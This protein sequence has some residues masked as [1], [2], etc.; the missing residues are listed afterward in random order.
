[1][2]GSSA[3]FIERFQ[4]LFGPRAYGNVF[5]EVHPADRPTRINLETLPVAQY[6][7]LW[8]LRSDA[9]DRNV[10]SHPPSDPTGMCRCSQVFVAAA[11]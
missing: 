6:L 2:S 10:E 11:D 4:D 9:G 1:M 8:V 3:R 7:C 5:G